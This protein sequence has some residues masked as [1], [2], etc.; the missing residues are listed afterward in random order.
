MKR[1]GGPVKGSTSRRMVDRCWHLVCR[2]LYVSEER[3]RA[4][5]RVSKLY[6]SMRSMVA[7]R[8]LFLKEDTD[9]K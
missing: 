6:A 5:Q 7:L 3:G 9:G 8:E 2:H 1:V 4:R